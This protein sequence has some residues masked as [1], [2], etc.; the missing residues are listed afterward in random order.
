MPAHRIPVR[1]SKYCISTRSDLT[2]ST[3]VLLDLFRF[4]ASLLVFFHHSEHTFKEAWLSPLASFG[5]DAVVF[6]FLLSGF[7]I[8]HNTLLNDC[9][10]RHYA[11]ARLARMYSVVLPAIILILILQVIGSNLSF[12]SID[13]ALPIREWIS[14]VLVSLTFLNQS[15]FIQTAIPTNAAYWSVCYEV[16]YYV[17]FGSIFYF[18]GPLRV[19]LVLFAG[20]V[21]GFKVLLMFPIWLLGFWFYRLHTRIQMTPIIA[22]MTFIVS[23]GIYLVWRAF[24]IDDLFFDIYAHSWG[25]AEFL[26]AK[27]GFSKRF[28]VDYITAMIILPMIAAAFSLTQQSPGLLLRNSKLISALSGGSFSLYLMHMPLLAFFSAFLPSALTA[29]IGVL[30]VTYLIASVTERKKTPYVKFFQRLLG[31]SAARSKNSSAS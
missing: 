5:H 1:H 24:N 14:I 19:G 30:A 13:E 22:A 23:I 15:A 21:A 27:L 25:G 29:M 2:K 31:D 12:P 20:T 16:W 3:S 18:R 10:W 7:V 11:A 9:G 4:I 28:L 17:L 26:D 6:F 8:S